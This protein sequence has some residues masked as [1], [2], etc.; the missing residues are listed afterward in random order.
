MSFLSKWPVKVI[1]FE[2]RGEN[3]IPVFDKARRFVD[4]E[5]VE[6]YQLKNK[7]AKIPAIN[8]ENLMP[9]NYLYLFSTT[10]SSFHP[11]KVDSSGFKADVDKS[12]RYLY[13]TELERNVTK[14][15]FKSGIEKWMPL[16]MI[17]G[18]GFILGLIFY[19][20]VP[21]LTAMQQQTASM[22]GQLAEAMKI[23]KETI[24]LR[25][26]VQTLPPP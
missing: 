4:K 25:C 16:V 17:I 6:C 26:S 13:A 20:T 18:T 9:G 2:K 5:N 22:A 7:K 10:A 24:E 21:K 12:M 19:M 8:F 11:V 3:I 1:I 14:F 15:R 23:L